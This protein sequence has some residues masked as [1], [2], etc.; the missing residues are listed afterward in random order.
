[1]NITSRLPEVGTTIFTTMSRLA[2]EHGAINLS[3]GFPDFPVDPVLIDLVAGAMRD[4]HNQYGPMPGL[5]A[6]RESIAEVVTTSHGRPVNPE[7]EITIT[8]GGTE[9]LYAAITAFIRPGD[10]VIL[11]D[12]SFDTYAPSIR[13]NGG[14]PVHI[15][16]HPPDFHPPWDEVEQR[17]TPRTRMILVNSP[18]NPCGSVLSAEDM[19]RLS[20]IAIRHDLL[21][22]S[23]EV[24]ERIIFDGHR[25]HSILSRPELA[26]RSLA[27]FSFGKTFHVTGWKSGYVVAA[28]ELTAE[29]RKT[30]Q[31]I[32]FSVNMPV[33]TA[34]ARYLKEPRNYQGLGEFF[35]QK[36]DFFLNQLMGSSLLP[37]PCHGSYFQLVDFSKAFDEKD[38]DLAVRLTRER[39]LASI[40][41]SFFYQD[42]TDHHLLRFCFAKREETLEAAGEILRSI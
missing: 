15:N 37:L 1:M 26:S 42:G 24:Y 8:A 12:P 4:G 32:N 39:K 41:V 2:Q 7:T 22:L 6:L 21:V 20:G 18:H 13:L 10:E 9:G 27:V 29:V 35:Q 5:M 23:D 40:P 17:I 30:H 19:D 28:P 11:F 34:L 3:Q 31:F 16:M 38:L 25:H 33:Q 36:R 14:V